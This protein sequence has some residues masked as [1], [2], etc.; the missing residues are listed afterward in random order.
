MNASNAIKERVDRFVE[1]ILSLIRRVQEEHRATACRSVTA[2]LADLARPAAKASSERRPKGR[3]RTANA[4]KT[5]A[6]PVRSG[7]HG[8]RPRASRSWTASAPDTRRIS[9]PAPIADPATA[10]NAT[11]AAGSD[12]EAVVL[13]TVR[14]LVR[15][16]TTEIATRCG[17]PNGSV[18]VALRALVARGRV[19]R[20]ETA[21]G[22]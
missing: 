21:R 12:R 1:E 2:M 6:T 14:A 9:A 5:V 20:A 11:G 10:V 18:Y 4:K 19:A 15:G 8:T 3:K 17:L 22:V 7:K 13:D 16:T